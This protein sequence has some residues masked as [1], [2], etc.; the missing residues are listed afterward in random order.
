MKSFVGVAFLILAL[1]TF[2]C[3]EEIKVYRVGAVIPLSGAAETY[4]RNVQNGLMLALEEINAAGGVKGK[5]LDVLM[6]NDETNEQTAVQKAEQ[7]IGNGI[8]VIIGGVT[9]NLA[10]A[11]APVGDKK[12]TVIL[13]PTATSPKLTGI[14]PYFFRNFPSDTREG[15]VMA[16]YAV[17]RMKIRN[18][19]I[20]YVDKE[21][22][23]GLT[24]IFKNRFQ[25]LGGRVAYEKPYAEG[26]TDFAANVKEIKDSGADS[27]YLPGYYTEIAA[28]LNELKKQEVNLKIL[29]VQGMATPMFLEIAADAAEGVVY[30][31]PPY[32]PESQEPSIQKF[33]QAYRQ[34]FP[35]KP[36]VD[37]AF[38]YDALWVVA[39]AIDKCETY[40]TDLRAKIADTSHHGLTGEIS[41]NSGGDVDI[42]PRMFQVKGG[43]FE[44]IK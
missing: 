13:S 33:V 21:Y 41:F 12:K 7:L 2:A 5:K 31:Q 26:T 32:D 16:E 9:S 30:P 36:D 39:K 34:K 20:L 10:L 14:S 8:P 3:K 15:R 22:G 44:P 37:A 38:A 28:I 17:R 11:L 27:V 18:V 23:Q 42:E 6:E 43:K 1:L 4:G 24:Q 29:S 19:A 40:P 35:T 25:E